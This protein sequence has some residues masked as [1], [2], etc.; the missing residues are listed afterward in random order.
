MG[1]YSDVPSQTPLVRPK[2]AIYTPKVDVT[3][4]PVTFIWE[5]PPP[6]LYLPF[7]LQA[8]AVVLIQNLS[9]GANSYP[10]VQNKDQDL[11][12]T[13]ISL[14][15]DKKEKNKKKKKEKHEGR[16]CNS[17]CHYLSF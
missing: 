8:E 11:K 6:R 15:N 5:P 17:Y 1:K 16:L 2:S 14:T 9:D 7:C 10:S 12:R 13:N 4:I 3:S